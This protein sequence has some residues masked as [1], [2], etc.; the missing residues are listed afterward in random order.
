[1]SEDA[2]KDSKT[3][4]PTEK[5]LQ[6]AA[7]KGNDPVSREAPLFASL[8]AL[9]AVTGLMVKPAAEEPQEFDIPPELTADGE[10]TL[11][12]YRDAGKGGNGRGCQVREVWLIRKSE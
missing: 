7:E 10:L 6:D 4:D 9:L 2:D 1:M 3:E 8:L 11:N 12:W 5:K